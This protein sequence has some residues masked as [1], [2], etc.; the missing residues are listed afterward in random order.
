MSFTDLFIRRPVFATVLSL[1]VVLVGLVAYERLPVREYPNIDPPVVNV[2]TV[3]RGASAQIVESQV[4]NV[5]EDSIAGIEGIDVM[6]SKSRQGQSDLT[7]TFELSR[8]PDT[9][10]ADV[11]DRVSRVRGLLPSEIEEPVIQKVEADAQPIIYMAFSSP[12]HTALEL[13]DYADRFVKDQ[14][15]VLPGVAEVRILGERRFAMR[16]WLDPVKLA[17]YGLSV[18]AVEDALRVQNVEIP[19]GSIESTDREFTVLSETDLRTPEQFNDLIIRDAAGYL[20]RLRDVGHAELGAENDDTVVRFNGEGAVALGVVKQATANP[21]EVS[22][23]I[24]DR[25]PTISEGLPEGMRVDVA[26]DS[27]VFIERSI[28]NVYRTIGEAVLLVILIIFISLRS[29]RATF[30]P[31]VTIPISLIGTAAAMYAFGFSVNTLTLLAVVLAIGL[32]VDDAIVVLENVYRH[33]EDGMEPREAAFK[34]AREIVFP[35][36]GMS[37]TL[38]AVYVPIGFM[39]G[40]TGRLFTEFA[41]ALAGAVLVSGFVALTL[42]PMMCAT[43]LRGQT[44]HGALY[45]AVEWVLVGMTRTYRVVLRRALRLRPL[46]LVV[47]LGI[48]GAGGWLYTQLRSELAPTEDQGTIIGIFVGPEG[49]TTSYMDRYAREIEAI[50]GGVEQARS[51]FVV[52]GWPLKSQG[53]SFVSL[54]PWDERDTGQQEIAQSLMPQMLGVPGVL[55]F[56]ISPAPLGQDIGQKPVQFVIQTSQSYEELQK[57]VDAMMAKAREYPGL[58]NL[59]TDLKLNKP[60]LRVGINR[61]KAAQLGISVATV[62][63]A[64]ETLLGGRQV[65]RFKQNNEQYDVIVQVADADRRTP[66]DLE[67]I[68]IQTPDGTSVQLANLVTLEETVAPQELNHFNQLRSASITANVAPGYAIGDVVAFFQQAANEVL[69]PGARTDWFGQTREYLKASGSLFVTFGLALA[70][71]FLVLAAQFESFR[72]PFVIMLSVPLSITGGLLALY[73][74]GATLN[75]YSQVGLVTLIGLITKHGILI[76][77]FTNQHRARGI[78]MHDAVIEAS[79]LRLRPILMTTGAMVLGAVPLMLAEGAGAMSRQAIGAVIGGG[80]IVGT[81]FTLFVVPTVYTYIMPRDRRTGLTEVR[82]GIEK[83][84]EGPLEE[85]RRRRHSKGGE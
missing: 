75:I 7:I 5:L 15:Q 61:D 63:R 3:Y 70:F 68:A 47:A 81:F 18:T 16:I 20:V 25:L 26:Y 49:A 35:V 67:K 79:T 32:V 57:Q 21:L 11:R 29:L 31:L 37:L 51:Y 52:S 44:Q 54:K 65:T 78:P 14:L 41:L 24:R 83:R 39:T 38:A 23:A 9:A 46:V 62:G 22:E 76:V 45:R 80:L 42:T 19:S 8:D 50:Y 85:P 12:N 58:A 71:I 34:G 43:L 10:A 60:Q 48:A 72:G 6:T 73:L 28:D 4:T 82:G 36:I 59:E 17:G 74:T 40:A 69:A 53:I 13:T 56:A 77:E 27:S 30:I 64:L 84:Q 55:A 33:I 2:E 66:S 1:L